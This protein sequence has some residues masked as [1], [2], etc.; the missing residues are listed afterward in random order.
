MGA[1]VAR[2]CVM[3][4]ALDML[5]KH[6]FKNKRSAGGFLVPEFED[7]LQFSVKIMK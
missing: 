7:G 3:L 5:E 1:V 2:R 4:D 6:Q